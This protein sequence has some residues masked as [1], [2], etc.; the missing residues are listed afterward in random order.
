MPFSL[1]QRLQ[2]HP[3]LP[4]ARIIAFLVGLAAFFPMVSFL[5]AITPEEARSNGMPLPAGWTAGVMNHGSYYSWWTISE[6]PC[7]FG[8]SVA[9]LIAS[10][11]FIFSTFPR[12]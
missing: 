7:L 6:N 8:L 2:K 12:R 10:V 5:A 4:F 11:L 3:L 1:L 9:V